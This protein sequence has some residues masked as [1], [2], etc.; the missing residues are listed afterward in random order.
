[1]LLLASF[2]A[3]ILAVYPSSAQ[4]AS[5]L[6]SPVSERQI[7]I[8]LQPAAEAA[9]SVIA[10]GPTLWV[11]LVDVG[12]YD[13]PRIFPL[14]ATLSDMD[15]LEAVYRAMQ[16]DHR[17]FSR[18]IV[19]RLSATKPNLP[20][21]DRPKRQNIRDLFED[22]DRGIIAKTA[23]GDTVL[24]FFGGHGITYKG[25]QWILPM[26]AIPGRYEN[27]A[28]RLEQL[29]TWLRQIE[30]NGGRTVLFLDACRNEVLQ[31]ETGRPGA[32]QSGQ[33]TPEFFDKL[34]ANAR[35][36]A[37]FSA[38]R[39]GQY[40]K[41]DTFPDPL[42]PQA[43]REYGV[44]SHFIIQGLLGKAD[45]DAD[46]VITLSELNEYA[47]A[48]V[49]N[50]VTRRRLP[51]QQPSLT[52][53]DVSGIL[54]VGL[55]PRG[56]IEP[57]EPPAQIPPPAPAQAAAPAPA[58][59]PAGFQPAPPPEDSASRIS[60]L[61][62]DTQ[63]PRITRLTGPAEALTIAQARRGVALTFEGEGPRGVAGYDW[64]LDG[65]TI[66]QTAA[67]TLTFGTP[68]SDFPDLQ[69]GTYTFS[70]RARDYRQPVPNVSEWQTW[71]IQ[72]LPNQRPGLEITAPTGGAALSRES[73]EVRWR[74][75]D[76]DE[77]RIARAWVA[78]G[79]PSSAVEVKSP[80]SA[81]HRIEALAEGQQVVWVQVE[82]DGAPP[83]RSEW[84][85]VTFRALSNR[86]PVCKIE[87][88]STREPAVGETVAVRLSGTDPDGD[89]VN[90]RLGESPTGPWKQSPE[91]AFEWSPA[92]VGAARLYAQ[93]V[94]AKGQASETVEIALTVVDRPATGQ[95]RK[96]DLGGGVTMNL[97]YIRGGTFT[98][99]STKAEQDWAVS[100][101]AKREWVDREGPQTRVTLTEDFWMGETEVTVGQFKRFVSE[102]NH[103]T[104]A[105]QKG[106]ARGLD[107]ADGQ[108]K[109]MQGLSWRS[110][111]FSQGDNHPVVCVSWDDAV[112]YCE[113]ASRKSGMK[114]TLPTEAQWEYA[115]RAGTST[116]YQWG[117][118]PTKGLGWL[119][120][121]DKS[122]NRI[123]EG[124][125]LRFT[126]SFPFDDGY[127]YTSPVGSFRK[128]AWGLYDMHGNVWEWCL[129]W[130]AD[131]LPG[132]SVTNP[133]GPG[134]GS[135]RV[136]RG[137]GWDVGPRYCRS[138][139]RN[140]PSPEYR[141]INLGFR[142]VAVVQ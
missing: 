140:G 103:R 23:P 57:I 133:S 6:P 35:G 120:A 134:S 60:E 87:S 135:A 54:A 113:W 106:S 55:V 14:P 26:D 34:L 41:N 65:K 115:C 63:R 48:Q 33:M 78:V 86:P 36:R 12:R 132:G 102:T 137:G 22:K 3:F 118:D 80:A 73:V 131:K 138:A 58:P 61:L 126:D 18:C 51:P 111:G 141:I 116:R 130:Y 84:A 28:I 71:K 122:A 99:G 42:Q 101:G 123:F 1:M 5:P 83:M 64:S 43:R 92:S 47:S 110:P 31:P 52:M 121:C 38:V 56:K 89:T 114:V 76:P 97:V 46:G 2:A 17:L 50:H 30:E 104:T 39:E 127:M 93:A 79:D 77:N 37:I 15:A 129:D 9:G 125:S 45:R 96:V 27:T 8:G 119:N 13:H 81:M 128:N 85:R 107:K 20:F 21:E 82:D 124:T 62:D 53:V 91:G 32:A 109:D 66:K 72:I 108:W 68:G 11:L 44:F 117:D 88:L 90:Y 24:F 95:V 69:P 75:T 10:S 4:D 7:S 49:E 112:A 74:A 29:F 100:Q 70:V 105:E 139:F 19:W 59:P 25:E 98:M 67:G 142:A 94:D 136:D 16:P 40:A